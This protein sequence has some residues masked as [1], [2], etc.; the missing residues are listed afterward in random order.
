MSN[1]S[2]GIYSRSTRVDASSITEVSPIPN[3]RRAIP[4]QPGVHVHEPPTRRHHDPSWLTCT[5]KGV[6]P[7]ALRP[8]NQSY[9]VFL[10][11]SMCSWDKAVSLRF[12]YSACRLDR[13]PTH[14]TSAAGRSHGSHE[15]R[16]RYLLL[17]TERQTIRAL[18]MGEE[19]TDQQA[20]TH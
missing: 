9:L 10:T 5:T 12:N 1:R 7:N 13:G 16:Y 3:M 18:G 20:V 8:T 14:R 19:S 4:E 17:R 2:P 15:H 6:S 11:T